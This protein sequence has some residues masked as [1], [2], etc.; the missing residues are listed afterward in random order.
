VHA[1]QADS[2]IEWAQWEGRSYGAVV[3]GEV[4]AAEAVAHSAG[5]PVN[6]ELSSNAFEFPPGEEGGAVWLSMGSQAE[7]KAELDVDARESCLLGLYRVI[8]SSL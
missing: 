7:C 8:G 3:L 6:L 4:G 5:L 2:G 1:I